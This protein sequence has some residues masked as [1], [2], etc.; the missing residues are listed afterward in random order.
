MRQQ[1]VDIITP[2]S[3]ANTIF[4]KARLARFFD[5]RRFNYYKDEWFDSLVARKLTHEQI[6]DIFVGWSNGCNK[7]LSL[8]KKQNA[9]IVIESGSTHIDHQIEQNSRTKKSKIVQ[10]LRSKM[11]N[12]YL[13][14]DAIVVPSSYAQKSFLDR[15]FGSQKII[16]QK[17]GVDTLFFNAENRKENV[18]SFNF[19]F[20]SQLT[21]QKGVGILLESWQ[22]AAL[23]SIC[24]LTIAGTYQQE[25]RDLIKKY[26]SKTVTLLGGVSPTILR[27]LYKKNNVFILPTF[28]D[29]FGMVIAE[30]MAS[31]CCVLTTPFSAGPDLINDGETGFIRNPTNIDEW[32]QW[33]WWAWNNRDQVQHIGS[34]AAAAAKQ[35]TWDDYGSR[36]YHMYMNML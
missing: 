31:G 24:H 25:S 9:R 10:A 28:D 16:V 19:L 2:C 26:S 21:H 23:P 11:I 27:E 35:W 29:G 30:A 14:A 15:G 34:A 7:S 3:I 6:G 12:E 4:E 1:Y 36:T 5:R 22:K 13:Q 20:A 8:A 17:L 32:V 18:T 33:L